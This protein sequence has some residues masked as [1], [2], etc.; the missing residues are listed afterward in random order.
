MKQASS[1]LREKFVIHCDWFTTSVIN[2]CGQSSNEICHHRRDRLQSFV[3]PRH[4]CLS[5][6]NTPQTPCAVTCEN[7]I[8][9]RFAIWY[10]HPIPSENT[11]WA[12]EDDNMVYCASTPSKQD[13]CFQQ[14][15]FSMYSFVFCCQ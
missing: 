4:S 15:Y 12:L 7:P 9:R 5:F 10:R 6:W 11:A 2:R 1:I 8:S 3:Y 14:W 13:C